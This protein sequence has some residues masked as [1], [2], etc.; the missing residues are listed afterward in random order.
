MV[1]LPGVEPGS[2]SQSFSPFTRVSGLSPA[3]HRAPGLESERPPPSNFKVNPYV[4]K[5]PTDYSPREPDLFA[6]FL[7]RSYRLLRRKPF[8]GGFFLHEEILR[9]F[10]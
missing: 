3:T 5:R 7:L 2:A 8:L 9:F 10:I 1:D 6:D 4:W